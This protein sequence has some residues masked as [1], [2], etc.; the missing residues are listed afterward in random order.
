[1]MATGADRRGFFIAPKR[2]FLGDGSAYNWTIHRD[3]F[4]TFEPILDF[5]H[6]RGF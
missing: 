5:I 1:M 3:H 6:P 4:S 2:A